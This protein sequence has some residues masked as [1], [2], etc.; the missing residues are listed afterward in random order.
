MLDRFIKFLS[1]NKI[2]VAVSLIIAILGIII[3]A[4]APL[5]TVSVLTA[6]AI[7]IFICLNVPFLPGTGGNVAFFIMSI[8][9]T[10]DFCIPMWIAKLI[11]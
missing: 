2:I 4:L 9:V 10:A 11:F 3:G 5:T 8:I 1:R 7:I 6:I